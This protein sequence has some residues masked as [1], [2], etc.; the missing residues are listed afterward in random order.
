MKNKSILKAFG[1]M[2]L[3]TFV[4]TWVIPSSTISTTIT[5]GATQPVGFADIFS[6]IEIIASYFINPTIF[7]IFVGMFYG[8]ANITGGFKAVVNKFVSIFKDKKNLFIVLTV[9]FY[10]LLTALTGMYIPAF[11]FVPLSIA[12]LLGLKYNKVQSILATVGASTIGLITQIFTPTLNSMTGAETDKFVWVKVGLFVVLTVVTILYVIRVSKNTKDEKKENVIMFVPENRTADKKVKVKGTSLIIVMAL[13]L[14][15]F[16]LGLTPWNTEIFTKAYD[17]IKGIKIGEFAIFSSILGGFEYFGSWSYTSLYPTIAL[18]II[19]LSISNHLSLKEMFEASVEGAKKV[20]GIAILAGL[21]NIIVI[22]TLNSGFMATIINFIAK[23]GN[24][25]LVTLSSFISTPFMVDLSYAIQYVLSCLY[26]ATNNEAALQLFGLIVQ[27][28]FSYAMLI[29]P[30]SILLMVGL[31]Y[32]EED[33][34][35]WF[36]YIWKFLLA[37]LIA[38]LMAIL[39]AS[40]I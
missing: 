15:V 37:V 6:T 21:L 17:A 11:M 1:I 13:L 34:S 19:V 23:S 27:F 40:I 32:V 7:I 28:T 36:K 35:K 18:A 4:L 2:A 3:V 31:G 22:F 5:T 33:Y 10:A 30:T 8:V 14:I 25:A 20:L 12:V 29:A 39:V 16:I 26:Y 9:L 24:I 38:I